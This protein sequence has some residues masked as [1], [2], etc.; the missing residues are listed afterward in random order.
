[1]SSWGHNRAEPL[2]CATPLSTSQTV[3]QSLCCFPAPA[4][5]PHCP[6]GHS[7]PRGPA[8]PSLGSNSTPDPL[9]PGPFTISA[10]GQGPGAQSPALPG[11]VHCCPSHCTPSQPHLAPCPRG[12]RLPLLDF[13][14]LPGVCVPTWTMSPSRVHLHTW[15]VAL[16]GTNPWSLVFGV[17]QSP[18][19]LG[20]GWAGLDWR[21]LA[22]AQHACRKGRQ[23]EDGPLSGSGRGSHP[24]RPAFGR[25][26]LAGRISAHLTD[27]VLCQFF[28]LR[29]L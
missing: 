1:M 5:C 15:A 26:L 22:G 12:V 8:P 11:C 25:H 24:C 28:Q 9:T 27:I 18:G 14:P 6:W 7:L 3:F 20:Q 13:G 19:V 17:W 2:A 21:F 29:A 23:T 4:Q 16:G 10:A